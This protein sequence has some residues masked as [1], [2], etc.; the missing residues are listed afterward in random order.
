MALITY[1]MGINHLRQIGVLDV[2]PEDPDFAQKVKQASSIVIT[3]LKRPGEWDSDTDPED[4]VEYGQAQVMC[5]R[6]LG[7]LYRF[8]GDD[9][10][11][12]SLDDVLRNSG[13]S[14]L[15]DPSLA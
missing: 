11:D 4:D 13:S 6:V 15:R 1:D 3:H 7:W 5:L 10:R 8:R 9:E 2:S 14:M 12:Q